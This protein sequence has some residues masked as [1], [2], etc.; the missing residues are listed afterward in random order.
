MKGIVKYNGNHL[1]AGD[2]VN[3]EVIYKDGKKFIN[4]EIEDEYGNIF[5]IL[6]E[7]KQEV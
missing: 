3:G 4:A 7:V 5:Y 6:T 2:E 1:Y